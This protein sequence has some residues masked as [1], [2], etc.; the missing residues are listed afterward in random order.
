MKLHTSGSKSLFTLVS[1]QT[2][3]PQ[4]IASP[5]QVPEP[6]SK[7]PVKENGTGD[8]PSLTPD[9]AAVKL[10]LL[11][12]LPEALKLI[13]DALSQSIVSEPPDACTS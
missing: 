12:M 6:V 3:S 13:V 4:A 8:K 7:L 1:G 10:L 9:P 11:S 5:D 2:L